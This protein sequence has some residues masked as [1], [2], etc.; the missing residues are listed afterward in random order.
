LAISNLVIGNLVVGNLVIE[1]KIKNF[2]FAIFY[3]NF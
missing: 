3:L 1:K 2:K